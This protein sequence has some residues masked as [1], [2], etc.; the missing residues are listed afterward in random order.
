MKKTTTTGKWSIVE[1]NDYYIVY[2]TK[3]VS[4]SKAIS[5]ISEIRILK[6]CNL[7]E[8]TYEDFFQTFSLAEDSSN[9]CG[10]Q[11]FTHP[12]FGERIRLDELCFL[13][14]K[15]EQCTIGSDILYCIEGKQGMVINRQ[16]CFRW[17]EREKKI[18]VTAL[19]R[20]KEMI[21]VYYR[22]QKNQP[23][24]RKKYDFKFL[25]TMKTSA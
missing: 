24:K 10:L 15:N 6:D 5:F 25:K 7:G 3:V 23:N 22:Y 21:G 12:A 17:L 11:F 18:D 14:S 16:S 9:D 1:Q 20:L 8:G 13:A 4:P 2:E 19:R